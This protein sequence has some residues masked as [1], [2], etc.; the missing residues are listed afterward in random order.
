M[1]SPYI[2][3]LWKRKQEQNVEILLFFLK[4]APIFLERH[5]ARGQSGIV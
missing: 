1:I 5:V 3:A 2:V 4:K